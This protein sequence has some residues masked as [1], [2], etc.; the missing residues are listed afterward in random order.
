MYYDRKAEQ[1]KSDFCESLLN[2]NSDKPL[3]FT[4][5]QLGL[6]SYELNAIFNFLFGWNGAEDNSV[7]LNIFPLIVPIILMSWVVGTSLFQSVGGAVRIL[8]GIFI[9]VVAGFVFFAG[10]NIYLESRISD[11]STFYWMRAGITVVG[12]FMSTLLMSRPLMGMGFI[13]TIVTIVLVVCNTLSYT[14]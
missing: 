5:M 12:F 14:V 6:W 8:I 13:K 9:P 3:N 7:L 4:I 10:S 2:E 11:P 1:K